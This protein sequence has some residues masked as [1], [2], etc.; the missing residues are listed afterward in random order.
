MHGC[1]KTAT[2]EHT[3][4]GDIGPCE[5]KGRKTLQ[6]MF[7]AKRMM[8]CLIFRSEISVGEEVEYTCIKTCIKIYPNDSIDSKIQSFGNLSR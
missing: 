1:L 6:H 2:Y 4:I 5:I 7:E 8:S 3:K